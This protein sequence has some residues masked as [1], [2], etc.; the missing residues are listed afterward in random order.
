MVRHRVAWNPCV[1]LAKCS[2][3]SRTG[4]KLDAELRVQLTQE[5]LM[6]LHALAK[7]KGIPADLMVREMVRGF[8][9]WT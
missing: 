2:K 1:L 6:A 8:M 5:E 7:K 4:T 9:R 3:I